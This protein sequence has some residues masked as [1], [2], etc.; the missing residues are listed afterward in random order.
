MVTSM[1]AMDHSHAAAKS[2]KLAHAHK[3]GAHSR[4]L[5][6]SVFGPYAQD[7][8]FGSRLINPMELYHNQ[9]TRTQGPF[10]LRMFHRSWGIALIQC[11][12]SAPCA[13]LDFP[14]LGRFIQEIRENEYDIV[15]IT[16]IIPNLGKVR[17]MC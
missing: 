1:K 13:L 5:F 10:S 17:E 6:T 15:G 11:N 3:P 14:V 16:A 4:I 2:S 7:D 8:E 12:I 9:V